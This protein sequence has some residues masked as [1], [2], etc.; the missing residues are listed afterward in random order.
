[1]GKPVKEGD[2]EMKE[3][4][5][6]FDKAWNEMLDKK[7]TIQAPWDNILWDNSYYEEQNVPS[8]CHEDISS[9]INA[10]KEFCKE[11]LYFDGLSNPFS[12]IMITDKEWGKLEK[13]LQKDIEENYKQEAEK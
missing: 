1:M 4:T 9:F 2:R 6:N 8:K 13:S 3:K 10:T 5:P 11:Y 7:K 12:E